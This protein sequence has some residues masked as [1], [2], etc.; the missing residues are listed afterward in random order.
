MDST[1]VTQLNGPISLYITKYNETVFY[2]FGDVHKS[3]SKGCKSVCD[4]LI[5]S[6]NLSS[7]GRDCMNIDAAI[8]TWLL[9]NNARGIKTN[10]FFETPRIARKSLIKIQTVDDKEGWLDYIDEMAAPCFENKETCPYGKN[11]HLHYVDSRKAVVYGEIQFVDLF[12]WISLMS[13]NFVETLSTIELGNYIQLLALLFK[14]TQVGNETIYPNINLLFDA[15][16]KAGDFEGFQK[17]QKEILDS[18]LG[19]IGNAAVNILA[20]TINHARTKNKREW[21]E[22]GLV[23][24][25]Y[26]HKSAWQL[27]KLYRKNNILGKAL[28]AFAN[29]LVQDFKQNLKGIVN[30]LIIAKNLSKFDSDLEW[31]PMVTDKLGNVAANIGTIIMDVYTIARMLLVDSQENIVFAGDFHIESYKMFFEQYLQIQPTFQHLAYIPERG[32]DGRYTQLFFTRCIQD[33]DLAKYLDL[34]KMRRY[35]IKFQY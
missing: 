29:K 30:T 4:E 27:L 35:M 16:F 32:N 7:K 24:Q 2:L 11:V 10:F 8:H 34:D 21:T 20:N 1:P 19:E 15:N 31:A 5:N 12:S 14:K 3:R 6:Q 9:Y 25:V 26:M 18:Q 28:Y 33:P 22:K 13:R 17:L 23:K